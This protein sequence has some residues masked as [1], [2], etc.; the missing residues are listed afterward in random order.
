[1]AI[2][3]RGPC[4]RLF[5]PFSR[6][7]PF[8]FPIFSFPSFPFCS[9]FLRTLL[10]RERENL[11]AEAAEHLQRT[12]RRVNEEGNSLDSLDRPPNWSKREIS[13][14]REAKRRIEKIIREGGTREDLNP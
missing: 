3:L 5:P 14:K 10:F 13:E 2:I 4:F 11:A 9:P 7:F 12:E 8:P 6:N 1:M